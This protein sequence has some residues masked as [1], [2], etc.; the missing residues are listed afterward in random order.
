MARPSD[1]G[2]GVAVFMMN[3]NCSYREVLVL[4]RKGAHAEGA[5]SV[6]GGWIDRSDESIE[7][8]CRREVFE[9]TGVFLDESAPF[10]RVM[11]TTEDFS[12]RGFRSVTLYYVA[13]LTC[14]APGD[15]Y[16]KEPDKASEIKWMRLKSLMNDE[17]LVLFPHLKEAA[18]ALDLFLSRSHL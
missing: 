15:I 3:P 11:N 2:V 13:F 6:P 10:Y 4:K 7:A 14:S 8:A 16:L 17:E 5:W 9:E 1:V 12:E 18:W